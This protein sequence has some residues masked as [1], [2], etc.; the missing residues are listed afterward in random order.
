MSNSTLVDYTRISPNQ[1]GARNHKIDTITIHCVAGQLSVEALGRLFANPSYKASSNYGIGP[2]GRI[3]MY[4]EEGHCSWCSSNGAN[5][6]RAVTIECASDTTHP[7]AINDTVY[8]ALIRLC[9]DICTRNGIS[10]LRWKCDKSLIGQVDKQ[11]LTVHRW[12]A[13]KAC[14]G[15]CIYN[16]L[17]QIAEEVNAMIGAPTKKDESAASVTGYPATPF[18]IRVS[19]HGVEYHKEPSTNSAVRGKAGKGTYTIVEVQEQ[20]GKL[21]S[22]AGWVMLGS[23]SIATPSA[24]KPTNPPVVQKSIDELAREVI[25][26]K[27]G[28]GEDRKRR[29]ATAGYDYIAIQKRVNEILR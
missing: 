20:W 3:G 26:G 11:N 9:A 8:H 13:N 17:G 5:D 27:W 28:N 2:D 18:L 19:E 14:P 24:P 25:N 4:V 22:G 6:N 15:D 12:F 21:K 23:V 7:Y 1:S 10:Q 29:L 16:R